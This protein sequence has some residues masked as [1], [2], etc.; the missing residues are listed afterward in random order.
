V[1]VVNQRS[2]CR[3]LSVIIFLLILLR[4]ELAITHRFDVDEFEHVHSAWSMTQGLAL[5]KDFFEHHPPLF[6]FTISP[7]LHAFE[8]REALVALRLFMLPMAL[9]ILA[10]VYALA[11]RLRNPQ[12]GVW[13]VFILSTTTLFV[14]KSIEIRPDVPALLLLLAAIYLLV[15]RP[16][17]VSAFAASGMAAACSLAYT[18]K[19]VFAIAGLLAACALIHRNDERRLQLGL[20]FAG[21]FA[22]PFV[23]LWGYFLSTG[24]VSEALFYNLRFNSLVSYRYQWSNFSSSFLGSLSTNA[25][26]WCL[27]LV[28]LGRGLLARTAPDDQPGERAIRWCAV[29]AMLGILALQVPMRQYLMVIVSLLCVLL[30]V[31]V[32][33]LAEHL[34]ER[35]GA[36]FAGQILTVLAVVLL[37]PGSLGLAAERRVSNH[38]QFAKLEYVWQNTK[39]DEAVFDCWT[40]LYVFRPHAFFYHFL[41]PDIRPTLDR[42][43][44]SILRRD[45]IKALRETE[46]RVAFAD[47]DCKQLPQE[48]RLYIQN[49][50]RRGR[51]P[52]ILLRR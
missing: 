48:V 47:S 34:R 31:A 51:Y 50:Y 46:P 11:S 49:H 16:G 20:A 2:L 41:G 38:E 36:R 37:V 7:L 39:E 23:C 43:D 1:A 18:P 15:S 9:G 32:S 33:D 35:Q 26:F 6:Y 27:A 3:W 44:R 13:A 25:A 8:G 42:I 14:Q 21:G 17:S 52:E 40:G 28:A 45:L 24:A 29:G 5:Y 10:L 22:V 12:A 4:I 30:A 19:T